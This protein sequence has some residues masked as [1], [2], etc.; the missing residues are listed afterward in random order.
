MRRG[1][2]APYIEA[3]Q[4]KEMMP[5]Q[6]L[7]AR[8]VQDIVSSDKA[9]AKLVGF[10]AEHP[11]GGLLQVYVHVAVET[12]QEA[13]VLDSRVKLDH[14]RAPD[15][16]LQKRRRCFLHLLVR[17]WYQPSDMLPDL[18]HTIDHSWWIAIGL[19]V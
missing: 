1:L 2:A 4:P 13:A 3:M 16:L 19:V 15:G 17:Q 18:H 10:A 14:H 11:L 9:V 12:G 5:K 6:R 7:L 8:N